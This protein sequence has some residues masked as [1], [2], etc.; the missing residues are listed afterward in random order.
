MVWRN[1][2]ISTD[3]N[4]DD[5]DDNDDNDDDGDDNNKTESP[6]CVCVPY[7]G[8]GFGFK[9]LASSKRNL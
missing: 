8:Q 1:A 7:E 4:D 3:H 5:N 2:S 9:K 6:A